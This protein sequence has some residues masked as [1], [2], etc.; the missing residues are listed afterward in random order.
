M[1]E[2]IRAAM[3]QTYQE[4]GEAILQD[5]R[6]MAS[7]L[8]DILGNRYPG[9][10]LLLRQLVQTGLPRMIAE[11]GVTAENLPDKAAYVAE[12]YLWREDATLAA[13]RVWFETLKRKIEPEVNVEALANAATAGDDKALQ[14]LLDIAEQ[15]N[16]D[17]QFA[18]GSMYEEGCWGVPQDENQAAHWIRKAAVGYHKLAE[19][20]NAIAQLKLGDMFFKGSW[21]ALKDDQQAVFWYRKAAEQG[22][23]AAGYQLGFI[24]D[25]GGWKVPKDDQQAAHWYRNAVVSY[26]KLAEQ[27][28][29]DAQRTLGDM[30]S[31][32]KKGVPKDVQQATHW[33]RLAAEQYR[34]ASEQGD[35]DALFRLANM[36]AHGQ[37]VTRNPELAKQWETEAAEQGSVMAQEYLGTRYLLFEDYEQAVFW[38]RKAAEQGSGQAQSFLHNIKVMLQKGVIKNM[39]D[40]RP[41]PTQKT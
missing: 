10:R 17:A 36:Y 7:F 11:G 39:A 16:A 20:G 40:H 35:A 30:F 3:R 29:V 25:F 41:Q 23:A 2:E 33:Y 18:L 22:N 21:A 31:Q 13:A 12:T 4:M 37:G 32:G 38:F 19:Q 5:E 9:E 34:K 6:R 1:N 14:E 8:A 27:G 28:D 24:Y 26:R 15:G